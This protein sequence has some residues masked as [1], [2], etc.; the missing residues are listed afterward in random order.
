KARV[1]EARL[2][3]Q[4]MGVDDP[5]AELQEIVSSIH[6]ESLQKDEPLFSRKYRYPIFLAITIGMFN[7][8]SGINAILYYLNDIFASAGFS[9]V[10][11]DVQ[12]VAIGATNLLFTIVALSMIDRVGRKTLLLIG[13]AGTAACLGGVAAIYFGQLR[14]GLLLLF[15]V[16][17]FGF[18]AFSQGAVIW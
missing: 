2:V 6:L 4:R 15:L 5:E 14:Q 7:Q 1:D 17:F 11:S 3:L 9:K 8:L 18:F 10:S 16:A 13:A 12:A